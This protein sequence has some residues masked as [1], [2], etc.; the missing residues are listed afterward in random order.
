M[1]SN[2]QNFNKTVN[3]NYRDFTVTD[4][5]NKAFKVAEKV[6]EQIIKFYES[7]ENDF[8]KKTNLSE[9]EFK[10]RIVDVIQEV[11][12]EYKKG[13]RMSVFTHINTVQKVLNSNQKIQNK[14]L[15]EKSL[16]GA[17]NIF[18]ESLFSRADLLAVTESDKKA[19]KK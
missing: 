14:F 16:R 18:L 19:L 15:S 7:R 2:P 12:D 5:F 11:D 13:E 8:R 3:N 6:F 9:K 10:D 4:T 1:H 17:T